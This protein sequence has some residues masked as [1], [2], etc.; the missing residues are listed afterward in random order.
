MTLHTIAE[1]EGDE[2]HGVVVSEFF[3][4]YAPFQ[5]RASGKGTARG[6]GARTHLQ[7][8]QLVR[9]STGSLTNLLRV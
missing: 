8:Q 4:V 6:W 5:R 1:S 9:S 2:G 7:Q 3:S